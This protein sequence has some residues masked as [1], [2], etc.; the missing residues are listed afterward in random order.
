MEQMKNNY[1]YGGEWE[2]ERNNHLGIPIH[3]QVRKIKQEYEK[4]KDSSP[5]QLEIRPVLREITR[6]LSR[7]PLGRVR[8]PISV[9][10]S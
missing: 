1:S 8:Q 9:G 2:K 6:Q 10:D 3:S 7:S 4:I 5:P